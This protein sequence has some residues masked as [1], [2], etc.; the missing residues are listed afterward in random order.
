MKPLTAR[1]FWRLDPHLREV[2]APLSP[3][4]LD[5]FRLGERSE[6]ERLL[7]VALRL[8]LLR[9]SPAVRAS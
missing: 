1:W 8:W 2:L 6:R 9:V 3:A 4:Q 5:R 7:H